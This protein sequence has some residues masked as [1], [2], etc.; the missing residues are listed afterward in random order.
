MTSK[1]PYKTIATGQPHFVR[2]LAKGDD[3]N[4]SRMDGGEFLNCGPAVRRKSHR[5]VTS[6]GR[7]CMI[8]CGA[9]NL[10]CI[11]FYEHVWY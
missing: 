8:E 1:S 5:A 7:A 9:H 10:L 3:G 6:Y 11:A 2:T 4:H